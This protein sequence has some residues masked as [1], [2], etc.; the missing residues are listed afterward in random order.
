MSCSASSRFHLPFPSP[1]ASGTQGI[2]GQGYRTGFDALPKPGLY[3]S[4]NAFKGRLR[5]ASFPP[6]AK[7]SLHPC[8]WIFPLHPIPSHCPLLRSASV[9]SLPRLPSSPSPV[10]ISSLF[11]LLQPLHSS[12]RTSWP[13]SRA[14]RERLPSWASIRLSPSARSLPVP[15]P[16]AQIPTHPALFHCLL[17]ESVS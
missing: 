8:S 13:L 7:P 11:H 9:L 3:P 10:L 12:N 16:V 1:I 2:T 5:R 15:P 6:A 17:G 4:T 14:P